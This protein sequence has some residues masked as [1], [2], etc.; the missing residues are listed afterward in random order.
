[1]LI[2]TVF[3][4]TLTIGLALTSSLVV[5]EILSFLVGFLSVTPQILIPLAADLA[6]AERRA[7]AISIVLGGLLLGILSA[8][9]LAGIVA[10]FVTWRIVYHIAYS[11]QAIVLFGMWALL[12]D[13]PAKN[14]NMT[15]FGIL[16]TM[17]KLA[18]TE[19]VLIQAA[20]INFGSA[21]CFSNYWV[22]LTFLLGGPPYHYST[23]AFT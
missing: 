19:P 1:M 17:A 2:L 4:S 21:A 12:P 11:V 3:T 10:Q 5:F 20:L 9:V 8:R 7:S 13:F 22:T 23:Y 15:Y 16:T 14:P 6:P 18:V